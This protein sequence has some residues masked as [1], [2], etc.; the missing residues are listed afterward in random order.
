[1]VPGRSHTK[2]FHL[3][4]CRIAREV[5]TGGGSR[6]CCA[7]ALFAQTLQLLQQPP[8]RPCMLAGAAALRAPPGDAAQKPLHPAAPW[9]PTSRHKPRRLPW[10]L[11]AGCSAASAEGAEWA[12]APIAAGAW[13]RVGLARARVYTAAS[14]GERRGWAAKAA[15]K[16]GR[17]QAL[18]N[19]VGRQRCMGDDRRIVRQR[20]YL[21]ALAHPLSLHHN[22][23]FLLAGM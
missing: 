9:F 12:E 20:A 15:I 14:H 8:S 16:P 18:A 5:V 6:G 23:L 2:T 17:V 13:G 4:F 19:W 22:T 11:S 1:M 21:M 10:R 3:K 7:Q